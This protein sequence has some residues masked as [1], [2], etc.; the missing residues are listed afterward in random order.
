METSVPGRNTMFYKHLD[1]R[2]S[3]PAWR[4]Y[5]EGLV[6]LEKHVIKALKFY[7]KEMRC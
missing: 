4:Q 2:E 1:T 7:P 6:R 3:K 5:K